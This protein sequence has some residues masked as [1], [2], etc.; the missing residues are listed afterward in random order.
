MKIN[1]LNHVLVPYHFTFLHKLKWAKLKLNFKIKW[2]Q[3]KS[4][5]IVANKFVK[6]KDLMFLSEVKIH[7][8]AKMLKIF[9]T[10]CFVL[11]L[12]I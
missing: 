5:K 10:S 7:H 4:G 8:K 12:Y 9:K 3:G 1:S 6:R 11:A 2:I